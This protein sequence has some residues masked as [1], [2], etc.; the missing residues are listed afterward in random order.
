M[1]RCGSQLDAHGEREQELHAADAI[2]AQLAKEMKQEK[3][4]EI[5]QRQRVRRQRLQAERDIRAARAAAEAADERA[6]VPRRQWHGRERTHR[7]GGGPSRVGG[8]AREGGRKRL[9]WSTRRSRRRPYEEM[10]SHAEEAAKEVVLA[11]ER[12]KRAEAALVSASGQEDV[13]LMLRQRA[14]E[15]ESRAATAERSAQ[16]A[17]RGLEEARRRAEE[18]ERRQQEEERASSEGGAATPSLPVNASPEADEPG[19]VVQGGGRA[20]AEV[21]RRRASRGGGGGGGGGGGD[22]ALRAQL[23]QAQRFS[24]VNG[25]AATPRPRPKV[26]SR[27]AA[28]GRPRRRR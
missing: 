14:E 19:D 13:A 6:A 17:E 1:R 20:H 8:C 15:A 10:A 23:A 28:E 16:E 4:R 11:E 12:A 27:T 26:E 5:A 22:R 3:D 21:A 18:A 24:M 7:F 2:Y 9:I 25:A